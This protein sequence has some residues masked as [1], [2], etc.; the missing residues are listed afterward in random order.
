MPKA[1]KKSEADTLFPTPKTVTLL[2]GEVFTLPIITW[3]REIRILRVI[4]AILAGVFGKEA[5]PKRIPV[6]EDTMPEDEKAT[7]RAELAAINAEMTQ[8]LL[9]VLLEKG[10]EQIT[11]VASALFN[12]PGEWIEENVSIE[13]ILEVAVPFLRNKQT[14]ILKALNPVLPEGLAIKE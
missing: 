1:E 11:E 8:H 10:P 6:I 13:T 9:S 4:K 5:T 2:D 3:G 12:K 14:T 7:I